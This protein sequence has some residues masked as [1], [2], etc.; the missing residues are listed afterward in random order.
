M[1]GR[2]T[3]KQ[4]VIAFILAIFIVSS[5]EKDTKNMY[6]FYNIRTSSAVGIDQTNAS[7]LE[8]K[9]DSLN[10]AYHKLESYGTND[11]TAVKTFELFHEKFERDI[12]GI[13]F[14]NIQA[15]SLEITVGLYHVED[16]NAT[17]PLAEII[18]TK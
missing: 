9:V 12:Q 15:A 5:C 14:D 16:K 1:T 11:E 2:L 17:N 8:F 18:F 6:Y 13:I 7:R 10:V 3:C 4:T